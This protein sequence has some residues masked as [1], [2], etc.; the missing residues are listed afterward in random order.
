LAG[1]DAAYN[2]AALRAV[3]CGEDRGAHRD[4]LLLSAALALEV[5]GVEATPRAALARAAA[6]ID[7]G[8]A[9][10]LLARLARFVAGAAS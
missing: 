2:A 3:L 8:A 4:A 9:R 7:T 1:G 6:A 5:M 10:D